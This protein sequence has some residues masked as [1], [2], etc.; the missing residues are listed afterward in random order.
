MNMGMGEILWRYGCRVSVIASLLLLCAQDPGRTQPQPPEEIRELVQA[1]KKDERGPY[2][3]IRWFCPDGTVLPPEK[4]CTQPG[5]IQHAVHKDVVRKLAKEQGLYLGQILAGTAF[6]DFLDADRE[7]ARLKQYQMEKYLQRVDDGWILR[8]AR[9]YRG[10]IQSEDEEIW[11]LEFLTRLAGRDE[12]VRSQFY[13]LRQA[14]R[15]IPHK[16]PDDR[17]QRIRAKS[18]AIAEA[19]PLFSKLRAKLHG[20]PEFG[21]I[22]RVKDF[23][24]E[25]REK[26]PPE[27][28]EEIR[29]LVAELEAAWQP[30]QLLSLN[31]YIP[32]LP[33]N[34]PVR[35][36]LAELVATYGNGVPAPGGAG[37]SMQ[38]KVASMADLLWE[39]RKEIGTVRTP[40]TRLVLIDLSNQVEG[41]LFLDAGRW[42]PQTTGEALE[43]ACA[44]A[45]STAGCG[46]LEVWEWEAVERGVRVER[47]SGNMSLAS[48]LEILDGLQRVV[49]W[50]AGMVRVQYGAVTTLFS[51]F[52]P[53]AAGFIDDRIHSSPLLGL[54][55]VTGL[56]GDIGAR[57][58][59]VSS[60]V[61]GRR[62][63]VDGSQV[64]RFYHLIK[65]PGKIN[66][67]PRE[68]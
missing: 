31:A 41:L 45:K 37:I 35:T 58:T 18:Q 29:G 24:K 46:Y 60:D 67:L 39:I 11:G 15:D 33:L 32:K 52:E 43:K 8:R 20:Q 6:D 66:G 68:F 51:G 55:E 12:M 26:I 25:N 2:K 61:F 63:Q 38:T 44:L 34:S 10:A 7:N 9:Y 5:G 22:Q 21:D 40:K 3:A 4:R 65:V 30:A 28:V 48:Y 42:K 1:F 23:Q 53:A 54:G 56:L 64:S 36:R 19:L 47:G 50:G 57:L 14:A 49:E 17:W 16:A 13:L 62:N 59:G 27:M